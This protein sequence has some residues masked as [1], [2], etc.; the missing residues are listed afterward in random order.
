MASF[1]EMLMRGGFIDALLA[2]VVV[3]AVV[4]VAIR[5][6][7]GRG[8]PAA[9]LVATLAAGAFLL[10]ALRGALTGAGAAWVAGSLLMAGMAH[11]VDLAL[12][13]RR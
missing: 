12:R 5:A 13:W 3:E 8:I 2:L 7:T 10:V 1:P 11:F 9:S 6:R 4:L